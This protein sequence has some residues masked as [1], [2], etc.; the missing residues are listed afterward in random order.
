MT[1]HN[2]FPNMLMIKGTRV[3]K[4]EPRVTHGRYI[5]IYPQAINNSRMK[6]KRRIF[7]S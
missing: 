2:Y 4:S 3:A 7:H 1:N 6:K 5:Y